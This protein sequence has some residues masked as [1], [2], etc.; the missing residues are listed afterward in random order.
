V[1]SSGDGV[2][3]ELLH[4]SDDDDSGF[5]GRV[6]AIVRYE[7]NDRNELLMKFTATT[8]QA[9]HVSMCNHAYW[10]LGGQDSGDILRHNLQISADSYTP[11]NELMIPTGEIA[12]VASTPLDFHNATAIGS[13]IGEFKDDRVLNGG[14]DH[15]FVMKDWTP[16]P[17]LGSDGIKFAAKLTDP[18]SGIIHI[19]YLHTY[20]HQYIPVMPKMS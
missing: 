18:N 4:I 16:T 1:N 2:Y 19:P 20:F 15:N 3:V 12:S 9:T 8:T 10:N 11:T 13:R 7:L 6:T 17:P 5:P 14:Y